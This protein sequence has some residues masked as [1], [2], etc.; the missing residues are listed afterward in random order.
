MTAD[1]RVSHPVIHLF[2]ESESRDF[3]GLV[4]IFFAHAREGFAKGY[5]GRRNCA[6]SRTKPAVIRR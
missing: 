4:L 2:L 5:F 1:P 3:N 6:G